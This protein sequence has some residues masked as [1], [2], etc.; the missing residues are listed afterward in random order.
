M[1]PEGLIHNGRLY[2]R[3]GSEFVQFS[4]NLDE[5]GLDSVEPR[6]SVRD[7]EKLLALGAA[8]RV[9][10]SPKAAVTFLLRLSEGVADA[11][12]QRVRT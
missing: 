9:L 5:S 4:C 1:A 12:F 11:L 6:L 8:R 2:V 7:V 10:S 3:S